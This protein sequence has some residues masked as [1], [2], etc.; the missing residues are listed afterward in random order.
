MNIFLLDK[1]PRKCANSHCDRHVVKMILESAQMLCTTHWATGAV[2]PYKPTHINHPCTIWVRE[3]LENYVF[4]CELAL[5]LC[6]EYTWRYGR[7]HKTQEIIEWCFA[8]KPKLPS[9]GLTS[10][11]QAMPDK[12]K[13]GNA[14]NSYRNYYSKAKKHLL[15]YTKRTMPSWLK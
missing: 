11:A 14:V 4:L 3:S 2:A 7:V 1:N 9:N 6:R 13:S 15:K 12:F 10:F 8:N 5:E